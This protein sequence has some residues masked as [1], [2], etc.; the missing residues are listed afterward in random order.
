MN[1]HAGMCFGQSFWE[2][3][4]PLPQGADINSVIYADSEFVAVCGNG[5]VLASPDGR[6]WDMRGFGTSGLNSI[7]YAAQ[8]FVAVGN[9]GLIFI[10][11]DNINWSV[12][13]SWTPNKIYSVTYGNGTFV[14]TGSGPGTLLTSIDC[15]SELYTFF[16]VFVS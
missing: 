5:M 1:I 16:R 10:S 13:S 8:M 12:V 4:N 3:R 2:W 14:A 6:N 11:Q 15:V 7:V 9:A